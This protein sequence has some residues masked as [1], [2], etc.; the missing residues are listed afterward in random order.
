MH[1]WSWLAMGGVL[2]S[3][4]GHAE[5]APTVLE[6]TSKWTLDYADERCSLIRNFGSGDDALRLQI[7]SYGALAGFRVTLAGGP[8]PRSRAPFGDVRVAFPADPVQREQTTAIQGTVGRVPAVSF[9]VALLPEEPGT[10][11]RSK[12]PLHEQLERN[13]EPL[14]PSAEFEARLDSMT[15]EFDNRTRVQLQLHG[16]VAPLAAM[17]ECIDN[18]TRSWGLDPAQERSLTREPIPDP[19]SV[20]R[21]MRSYP[22]SMVL[23]GQSAF[24]P[25]RIMVDAAGTAGA[26]VVQVPSVETV[27][28]E[29]VCRGLARRFSPALDRDARPV[30]SVYR[31][32]VVYQMST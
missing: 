28:K 27:F 3:A 23:G 2:A 4:P 5:R 13:A 25:V 12:A 14:R 30:A 17:R 10:E 1:R 18:L 22:R 29:A 31:T 32:Y 9:G 20:E 16:M 7:D 21:V 15:V 8:V 24:V 6:P 11:Q 26:C 19:S